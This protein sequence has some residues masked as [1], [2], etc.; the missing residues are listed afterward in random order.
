[1][2]HVSYLMVDVDGKVVAVVIHGNP[3]PDDLAKRLNLKFAGSSWAQVSDFPVHAR[4][5]DFAAIARSYLEGNVSGHRSF[6][7]KRPYG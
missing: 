4:K 2:G 6:V 1:M 7:E 3:C 5:P